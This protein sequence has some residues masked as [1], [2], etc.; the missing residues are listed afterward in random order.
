MQDGF[1]EAENEMERDTFFPRPSGRND[2]AD[3]SD[4][5]DHRLARSLLIVELK[6]R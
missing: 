6:V 3:V 1:T 5:L 4:A 2:S